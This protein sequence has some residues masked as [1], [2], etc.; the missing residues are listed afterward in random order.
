MRGRAALRTCFQPGSGAAGLTRRAAQPDQ[1][2][3]LP[4]LPQVQE[5]TNRRVED[6][7][8]LFTGRVEGL[9]AQVAEA[10]A[11]SSEMGRELQRLAELVAF[12]QEQAALEK[13][14]K[15]ELV[16]PGACSLAWPAACFLEAAATALAAFCPGPGAW[17]G[18]ACRA[19]GSREQAHL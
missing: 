7:F 8:A 12:L 18:A 13:E 11:E 6:R 2:C 17:P 14:A 15:H 9:E 1:R 16:G 19:A 10:K 4:F 5:T 3:P